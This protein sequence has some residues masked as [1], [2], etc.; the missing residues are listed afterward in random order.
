[1]E[2][3]HKKRKFPK[4]GD[5][6]TYDELEVGMKLVCNQTDGNKKE[7][8]VVRKEIDEFG[9]ESVVF[10][11]TTSCAQFYCRAEHVPLWHIERQ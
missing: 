11:S 1:M 6:M 9:K 5:G 4:D 8:I 7:L 2:L 3:N 10:E